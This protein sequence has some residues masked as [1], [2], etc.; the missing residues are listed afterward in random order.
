MNPSPRYLVI[1][2]NGREEIAQLLSLS[3][4]QLRIIAE[5]LRSTET[6][7]FKEP[8]YRRIANRHY[9]Q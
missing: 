6:L 5:T 1:P 7:K 4:K 8:S 9:P 3:A 2:D